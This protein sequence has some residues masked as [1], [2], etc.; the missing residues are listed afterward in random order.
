[1]LLFLFASILPTFG[2]EKGAF[3]D[4]MIKLNPVYLIGRN[5]G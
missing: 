4:K 3:Y 1:M 2:G 5:S